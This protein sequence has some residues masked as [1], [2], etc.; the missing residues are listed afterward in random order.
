MKW[1]WHFSLHVKLNQLNFAFNLKLLRQPDRFYSTP[2]HV[3]GKYKDASPQMLRYKIGK[4]NV[5][6]CILSWDTPH[7]RERFHCVRQNTVILCTFLHFESSVQIIVQLGRRRQLSKSNLGKVLILFWLRGEEGEEEK[8]EAWSWQ[9]TLHPTT[10]NPECFQFSKRR[11]RMLPPSSF[12]Q[13]EDSD[14]DW[15][16]SDNFDDEETGRGDSEN[17]FNCRLSRVEIQLARPMYILKLWAIWTENPVKLNCCKCAM[18]SREWDIIRAARVI[19][20]VQRR[21][22]WGPS[23]SLRRG[24]NH[25]TC[26]QSSPCPVSQ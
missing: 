20:A 21:L 1:T 15:I 4:P 8:L 9:W 14:D 23:C 10:W 11:I 5:G 25:W 6:L 26:P 13:K 3:G 22:A 19:S 7:P 12:L 17:W 18:F 16:D 2:W 24:N